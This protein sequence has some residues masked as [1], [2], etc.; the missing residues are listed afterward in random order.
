MGTNDRLLVLTEIL[1]EP[2]SSDYRNAVVLITLGM[3]FG[4]RYMRL[5]W[6]LL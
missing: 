3:A 4:A 6:T 5:K 1:V 2:M